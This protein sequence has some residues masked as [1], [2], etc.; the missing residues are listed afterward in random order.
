[1]VKGSF[2]RRGLSALRL[3]PRVA[4]LPG[5]YGR[6]LGSE[7]GWR[8]L[9]YLPPSRGGSRDTPGLRSWALGVT[10]SRAGLAALGVFPAVLAGLRSGQ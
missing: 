1:M 8:G 9:C 2:A 5:Q 3:L 6:I 4:E 7:W 10:A